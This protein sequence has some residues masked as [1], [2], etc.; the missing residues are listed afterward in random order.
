MDPSL[1]IWTSGVVG[2]WF[3]AVTEPDATEEGSLTGKNFPA[4]CLYVPSLYVQWHELFTLV[5][6]SHSKCTLSPHAMNIITNC[7]PAPEQYNNIHYQGVCSYRGVLGIPGRHNTSLMYT[8]IHL[9][10]FTGMWLKRGVIQQGGLSGS[11]P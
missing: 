6:N 8:A 5:T 9:A 2:N 11:E 7:T 1:Q 10:H 3:N 4:L